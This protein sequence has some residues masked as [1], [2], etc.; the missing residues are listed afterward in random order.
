MR[1]SP[2][3]IQGCRLLSLEPQSDSRGFFART[4]C[5]D[6][7]RAEGLTAEIS[8][9]SVSFNHLRG[10]LRGMHFQAEPCAEAK[11]VACIRGAIY[12]VVLDLR[13]RSPTYLRWEAF[14][15]TA[16]NRLR[17]F[18]PEGCAHG[19]QSLVDD[20]ELLYLISRPYSREHSRGVRY[21]DPCFGIEWPL[22]VT[23]ISDADRSRPDY[24][25]GEATL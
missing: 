25:P 17:L 22:A 3:K 20:S 11:V 6:E 19:F 16:E 13:P 15:L 1:F 10:T 7:L 5:A 14:E 24:Q 9:A 2:T 23:A 8:Q 4:W 18:V 12:D 21:N